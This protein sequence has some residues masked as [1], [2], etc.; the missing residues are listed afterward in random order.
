MTVGGAVIFHRFKAELKIGMPP[1]PGSEAK[2]AQ[3]AMA[4]YFPGHKKIVAVLTRVPRFHGSFDSLCVRRRDETVRDPC[5][6]PANETLTMPFDDF[7]ELDVNGRRWCLLRTFHLGG[8]TTEMLA[9]RQ[10]A[11][12]P[13]A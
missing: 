5:Q 4:E 6:V 9:P 7:D 8:V 1:V 11:L 3:D 10:P 12:V 2:I 13:E